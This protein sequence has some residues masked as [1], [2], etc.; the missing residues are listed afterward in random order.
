MKKASLDFES[1]ESSTFTQSPNYS[2]HHIPSNPDPPRPSRSRNPLN[3]FKSLK[4]HMKTHKGNSL[5]SPK[6]EYL[7]CK[8]IRGCKK[9]IRYLT[10]GKNP[11]KIVKFK[12]PSVKAKDVIHKMITFHQEN[13]GVLTD[14][15][16]T[17]TKLSDQTFK[18]YNSNFCSNFFKNEA[19]RK[20]FRFYIKLI[21]LD[22]DVPKL[23]KEFNFT[24]CFKKDHSLECHEKWS[25][26]KEYILHEMIQEVLS[27]SSRSSPDEW[28][29]SSKEEKSE[30]IEN[31]SELSQGEATGTQVAKPEAPTSE[32]SILNN[33]NLQPKWIQRFYIMNL[34]II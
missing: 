4:Q 13:L 21:F 20:L 16:K 17:D 31:K 27:F 12:K 25:H 10:Q 33:L 24:C 19:V 30:E 15:S 5:K 2:P 3:F 22:T 14:F 8:L 23:Q 6:K 29:Y 32:F 11:Q 18:S 34:H 26:L 7:R 28:A 9:C 1:C